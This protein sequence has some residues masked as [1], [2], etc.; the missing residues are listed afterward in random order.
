MISHNSFIYTLE[1]W[2]DLSRRGVG[3]Y[4]QQALESMP[5]LF[6]DHGFKLRHKENNSKYL[7]FTYS[8]KQEWHMEYVKNFDARLGILIRTKGRSAESLVR[9]HDALFLINN[10]TVARDRAEPN[11]Y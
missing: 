4:H 8:L 1:I 5:R 11:Q 6:E 9:L 7:G 2:D 3:L 10:V